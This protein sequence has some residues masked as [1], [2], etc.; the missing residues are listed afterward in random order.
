MYPVIKFYCKCTLLHHLITKSNTVNM[1]FYF[2]TYLFVFNH[3]T[4]LH[5][6][7]YFWLKDS[8]IVTKHTDWE[9]ERTHDF[10]LFNYQTHSSFALVQFYILYKY[11]ISRIKQASFKYDLHVLYRHSLDSLNYS[12]NH[13]KISCIV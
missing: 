1:L 2:Y 13:I 5:G 4:I 9:I 3:Q 7:G 6:S 10:I 12:E 11:K 8:R